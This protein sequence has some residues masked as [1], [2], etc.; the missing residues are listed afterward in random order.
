MTPADLDAELGGYAE[1]RFSYQAGVEGVP[2]SLTERLRPRFELAPSDRVTAEVVVE[3][4]LVQG[5]DLSHELGTLVMESPLG[6]TL[7]DAGCGYERA[8]RY[9]AAT[10]VFSVERL[11]VDWNLPAADISVGRQALRWGSG[12]VFHPTDLYAEVL[13]TE[14][15]REPR[16]VNAVKVDVPV[17]E[18]TVMAVLAV[19]DDLSGLYDG[20]VDAAGD[21]PVSG[22][23]KA[24]LRAL[25]T[26]W[27][28]IAQAGTDGDWFAG[29]DLR[30][31]LG[32]GWWVEGGW[33][34]EAAAPEV[35]VGVDY[36]FPILSRFYLAAEYR[37]DG[38]GAKPED[39]DFNQRMTGAT[40]P[41][42]CEFLVT[43]EGT[44]QTLGQHYADGAVQIL[45]TEDV[46]LTTSVVV[47]LLDG[48]GV[49][50]PDA[51]LFL[52]ERFTVHAGAQVPFGEDGEYRPTAEDLT[53]TVGQDQ[54]DLSPLFPDATVLGW[55][56]Y[57]F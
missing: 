30:G 2:W 25:E 3:G 9:D 29:A 49:L 38:T 35:V 8:P 50:V 43:T 6:E 22:A 39:Y 5:R 15:W 23:V 45:F 47:N 10:D 18:S 19:D 55:V 13:V 51:Q 17:G 46:G 24:T 26:D 12:L 20:S 14:P 44:R 48:T 1:V 4:N 32:V 7:D 27:A 52:G 31:T 40:L 54:V 53:Y 57:S 28:V 16:G 41:F 36:S 56:R 11:H 34:G 33:H 37:Y 21:I 42:D